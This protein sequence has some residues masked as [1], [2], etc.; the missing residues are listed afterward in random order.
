MNVRSNLVDLFR[1]PSGAPNLGCALAILYA[2]VMVGTAPLSA[3]TITIDKAGSGTR[4]ISIEG[5]ITYGDEKKFNDLTI[6]VEQANVLLGSQGGSTVAAIRIGETIRL[7]GYGTIVF[8]GMDCNSSCAL[9]WLAGTPRML[10]QTGRVG[11]HASYTG[12][13]GA[14]RE[15]GFGNAIVGRYLTLLNL[16]ERAVFF[17]TSA[18]P[19]SLNY[20]DKTKVFSSGIDAKFVDDFVPTRTAPPPIYYSAPTTIN[21]KKADTKFIKNIGSWELYVDSTLGEGCFILGR[22][23]GG[24]TLRLGYSPIYASKYYII[25]ADAKWAS[26]KL[27]EKYKIEIKFDDDTPWESNAKSV[28]IGGVKTLYSPFSDD[29]LFDEFVRSKM[30]RISYG[31]S[32]ITTMYQQDNAIAVAALKSCQIA[33]QR[34][35]SD[36]FA[37]K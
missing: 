20:Y 3:A 28:E 10:A 2:L 6:G 31:G 7:K 25:L 19:N 35:G 33:Q 26:L 32:V 1:T 4:V 16:P 5:E 30:I 36:P 8:N 14:E 11:F 34:D 29:S 18:S 23:K 17:A 22:W 24:T 13:N 27:G 12:G 15:S 9:I 37:R 21:T